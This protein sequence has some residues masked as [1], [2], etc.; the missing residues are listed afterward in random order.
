MFGMIIMV[1]AV[2]WALL[3]PA[4]IRFGKQMKQYN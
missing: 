2:A 4:A 3:P 1:A